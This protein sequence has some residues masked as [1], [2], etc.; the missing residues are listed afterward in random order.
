MFSPLGSF[1]SCFSFKNEARPQPSA[2]QSQSPAGADCRA[3]SPWLESYEPYLD[4]GLVGAN[5]MPVLQINCMYLPPANPGTARP[6]AD[7]TQASLNEDN[8]LDWAASVDI[9]V[10][11]PGG[12]GWGPVQFS[13]GAGTTQESHCSPPVPM[14]SLVVEG[15]PQ[16]QPLTMTN[17]PMPTADSAQCNKAQSLSAGPPAPFFYRVQQSTERTVGLTASPDSSTGRTTSQRQKRRRTSDRAPPKA[18]RARR[19][20]QKSPDPPPQYR[21]FR[22]ELIADFFSRQTQWH[23]EPLEARCREQLDSSSSV[24]PGEAVPSEILSGALDLIRTAHTKVVKVLGTLRPV[25]QEPFELREARIRQDADKI[26]AVIQNIRN[27]ALEGGELAEQDVRS[28]KQRTEAFVSYVEW[29]R[30]LDKTGQEAEA[31][32][33]STKEDKTPPGSDTMAAASSAGGPVEGS[34]PDNTAAAVDPTGFPS[35]TAAAAVPEPAGPPHSHPSAYW[36]MNSPAP[37]AMEYETPGFWPLP[38]APDSQ[39]AAYPPPQP[40]GPIPHGAPLSAGPQ[41]S[42]YQPDYPAEFGGQSPGHGPSFMIPSVSAFGPV[43]TTAAGPA[44]NTLHIGAAASPMAHEACVSPASTTFH[45]ASIASPLSAVS[46]MSLPTLVVPPAG[47]R[48]S[49]AEPRLNQS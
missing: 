44:S 46:P 2:S 30:E 12:H 45:P 31:K 48:S 37:G 49:R 23:M 38:P 9:A 22:P 20:R 14:Q 41:P 3:M 35:T 1:D 26:I 42:L 25:T 6:S 40:T 10:P 4:P 7:Q 29:V 47:R 15:P 18:R 27:A 28:L 19:S 43:P 21:P 17:F 11:A 33:S 36:P 24:P 32:Q 39:A 5:D 34:T 8:S 16:M 13:Q